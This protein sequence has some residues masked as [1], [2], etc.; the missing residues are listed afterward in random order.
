MTELMHYTQMFP[1]SILATWLGTHVA[2][3]MNELSLGLG[4][5]CCQTQYGVL[6]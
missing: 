2:G 1:G 4:R 3:I 6:R 5:G